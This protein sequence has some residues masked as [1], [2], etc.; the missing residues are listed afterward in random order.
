MQ[1][2]GP[3]PTSIEWYNP[4]GQLVSWNNRKE[5]N[6]GG[7][8]SRSAI[9]TFRSYQQS[10][11]GAYECRVAGPW[12][13]LESL[14]VCIGEG[15]AWGDSRQLLSRNMCMWLC[16]ASQVNL[17]LNNPYHLD[18]ACLSGSL[19]FSKMCYK[20]T[21][22]PLL[23]RATVRFCMKTG[24]STI[25]YEK[26]SQLLSTWS[27]TLRCT[28]YCLAPCGIPPVF[29]PAPCHN[30]LSTSVPVTVSSNMFTAVVACL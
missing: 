21:E 5:V 26:G 6:Q 10:Q 22:C 12:N 1:A 3:V 24:N 9:L 25:L 11:G 30:V 28:E 18:N 16:L 27:G 29:L 13:N 23:F 7:S 14:P 4:Q 15:H 2:T 17:C 20:Y 19:P 8:S